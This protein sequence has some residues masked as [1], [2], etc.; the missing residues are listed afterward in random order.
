VAHIENDRLIKSRAQHSRTT[1]SVPGFEVVIS[2]KDSK[3]NASNVASSGSHVTQPPTVSLSSSEISAKVRAKSS[4]NSLYPGAV[5]FNTMDTKDEVEEIDE[6]EPFVPVDLGK[7]D[8]SINSQ[9]VQV[10]HLPVKALPSKGLTSH[11]GKKD[12]MLGSYEQVPYSDIHIECSANMAS[13]QKYEIG[14]N[15]DLYIIGGEAFHGDEKVLMSEAVEYA[16]DVQ[17]FVPDEVIEAKEKRTICKKGFLVAILIMCIV[18]PITATVTAAVHNNKKQPELQGSS[19]SSP[20]LAPTGIGMTN[21]TSFIISSEISVPSIL[22]DASSPQNEAL[23]WMSNDELSNKYLDEK[24]SPA[25]LQRY[26]MA[27]LYFS[28]RGDGWNQCGRVNIQAHCLDG[29][30]SLWLSSETECNWAGVTCTD[31]I[32]TMLSIAE[33]FVMN[34]QFPPEMGQLSSLFELSIVKQQISGHISS[35]IG[36]LSKLVTLRLYENQLSGTLPSSIYRLPLLENLSLRDNKFTGSLLPDLGQLRSLTSLYLSNNRLTGTIPPSISGVSNLNDFYV[37][38]N[39]FTGTLPAGMLTLQGLQYIDLSMNLFSGT[40][41]SN[42]QEWKELKQLYLH[43]NSFSGPIPVEFGV[44]KSL[45]ILDLYQNE[46]LGS[47]PAQICDLRQES[48]KELT[49]NCGGAN[50]NVP[51]DCCTTCV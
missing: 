25:L 7:P 43:N 51:C 37:G 48:L 24:N 13:Q 2:Q 1:P 36:N 32:I 50:P 34:G 42:V 3:L 44:L 16:M 30:Q 31:Q 39:S 49:A 27:T 18:I 26:T 41:P 14:T 38:G 33:P 19:G 5:A 8:K 22:G 10:Q 40:V 46:F 11:E 15:E 17:E 47:M 4:N 45:E 12:S 21:L 9:E 23:R 35:W 20:T 28:T 6:N 29:S